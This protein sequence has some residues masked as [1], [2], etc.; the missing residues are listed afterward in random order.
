M[1]APKFTTLGCRLNAYETEAMKGLAAEA[2]LDGAVVVNT[3]AVTAEAVRQ[4]RQRIRRLRKDNPDASLIVT[5]CAAQTVD[6]DP[7]FAPEQPLA[8]GKADGVFD[9]IP[10]L[11]FDSPRSGDVGGERVEFFKIS[12]NRDERIQ[13]EMRVDSGN[14]NPHMSFYY[15]ISSYVGSESWERDGDVLVEC[16]PTNMVMIVNGVDQLAEQRAALG[17]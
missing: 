10:E 3:C 5:G 11:A 8:D 2:G 17:A 13:L 12:L 6:Y 4:A 7:D 9:V 16:D 14:L 15:G 1:S